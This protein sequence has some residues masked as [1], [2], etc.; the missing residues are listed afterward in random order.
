MR[1]FL[2]VITPATSLDLTVLVTAKEHLGVTGTALDAKIQNWIKQ[3][4]DAI[5]SHCSRVFGQETV[6]ETFFVDLDADSLVLERYPIA[7]ISSVTVDGVALAG[8]EHIVDKA[9][10]ILSRVD[11][12]SLKNWTKGKVEVT[13]LGGYVLLS[14]LP[15]DLEQACLKMVQY[16]YTQGSRDMAAKRVEV[17]GVMTVDYWVGAMGTAG[18]LPPDVATLVA[19]YVSYRM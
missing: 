15:Y 13:Y 4:S 12:D 10:G 8:T 19:P 17:P 2:E 7:S 6:K 9:K 5:A 1:K 18:E 11:G 16:A 3:A 14:G